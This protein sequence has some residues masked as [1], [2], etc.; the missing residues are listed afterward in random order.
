MKFYAFIK[1]SLIDS[2]LSSLRRGPYV[3]AILK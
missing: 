2:F 3:S 1:V